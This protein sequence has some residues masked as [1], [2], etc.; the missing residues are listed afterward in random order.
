MVLLHLLSKYSQVPRT[1]SKLGR[2][3]KIQDNIGSRR[4]HVFSSLTY[5]VMRKLAIAAS[6]F[7]FAIVAL[8]ALSCF[9]DKAMYFFVASVESAPPTPNGPVSATPAYSPAVAPPSWI[10]ASQVLLFPVAPPGRYMQ[11]S[12]TA[13]SAGQGHGRKGILGCK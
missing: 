3:N 5:A 12:A 9:G 8:L 2:H 13:Q 6:F 7:G 10:A 1:L 4:I 11:P